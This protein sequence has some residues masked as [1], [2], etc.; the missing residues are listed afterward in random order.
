[1]HRTCQTTI[2]KIGPDFG[3]HGETAIMIVPLFVRAKGPN[4]PN[5]CVINELRGDTDCHF[6]LPLFVII[7]LQLFYNLQDCMVLHNII[8]YF[9]S[10]NCTW[11]HNTIHP[12]TPLHG[13]HTWHDFCGAPTQR[14]INKNIQIYIIK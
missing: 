5:P 3:I 1:M 7:I 4:R 13:S 2:P 8:R 10:H 11:L 12:Y 9:T 6:R 14:S